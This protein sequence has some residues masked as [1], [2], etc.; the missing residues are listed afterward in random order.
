MND[1]TM[2]APTWSYTR[3]IGKRLTYE[4]AITSNSYE[5]FLNGKSL[6]YSGPL[7]G[8]YTPNSDGGVA[9]IHARSDIENLS[10]M[11]EE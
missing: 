7:S 6:K 10:G 4:V 11:N 1:K 8:T 5:I 9:F 3:S 2:K